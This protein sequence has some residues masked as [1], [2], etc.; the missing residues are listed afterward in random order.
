MR[1]LL[2]QLSPRVLHMHMLALLILMMSRTFVLTLGKSLND[3][4]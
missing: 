4:L 2:R 1:S 3:L